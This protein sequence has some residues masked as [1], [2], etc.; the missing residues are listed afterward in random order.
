[1]H[2]LA[3]T[4]N[5]NVFRAHLVICYSFALSVRRLLL[6]QPLLYSLC[7]RQKSACSCIAHP[8]SHTILVTSGYG[9]FPA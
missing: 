2:S 8:I 3:Q 7:M 6:H 9:R 1:M 5:S 4:Q